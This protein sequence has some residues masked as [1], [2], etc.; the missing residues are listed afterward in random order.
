VLRDS[1]RPR[2]VCSCHR[3]NFEIRDCLAAKLA[4]YDAHNSMQREQAGGFPI[5]NSMVA[6]AVALKFLH[7]VRICGIWCFPGLSLTTSYP[8][9]SKQG[10]E[11]TAPRQ[12]LSDVLQAHRSGSVMCPACL[13]GDEAAGHNALRGSGSQSL[14]RHFKVRRPKR[15]LRSPERPC[16]RYLFMSS[17]IPSRLQ[18]P[19]RCLASPP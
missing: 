6:Q 14:A 17:P 1:S 8:S 12:E 2:R 16:L 5:S 18:T 10:S 13:C 4:C 3:L 11:R 9:G 15:V 19:S 7:S